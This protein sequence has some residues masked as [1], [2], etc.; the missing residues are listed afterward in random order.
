MA[1]FEVMATAPVLFWAVAGISVLA[2]AISKSGFGGAFGAL[3]TPILLFV[4]PPKLAIGVLLPLFLVTDVW[5]VY[6]WRK[7]IDRRLL[8]FMCG[9]AV[10]G[11]IVGWALFDYLSDDILTAIIGVIAVITALS[12]GRKILFPGGASP[13]DASVTVAKKIWYR[14][15]LWCGLSGVSSFV[16]LSGGIPAQIFLLPHALARQTFVGTM[17]VFFLVINL[18]KLP[19][20]DDLDLFTGDT[21][22]VSVL[23]LPVIPV[24]VVIGKWLNRNMSDRIFYHISHTFLLLMGINLLVGVLWGGVI[25]PG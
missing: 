21:L 19:F 17:S 13:V 24:G 7:F 16:S 12:Y 22:T 3:S 18:A 2:V 14:A 1:G 15:P 6:L 8:V 20:Y 9:F 4:L 10:L 11:Q 23:L 25:A 5:V